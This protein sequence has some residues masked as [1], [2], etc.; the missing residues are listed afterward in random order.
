MPKPIKVSD[1]YF[2]DFSAACKKLHYISEMDQECG[3]VV[4]L[5]GGF[6]VGSHLVSLGGWDRD[7]TYLSVVLNRV[8]SDKT[9]R[10]I[11]AH[12]HPNGVAKFSD[13]DIRFTIG[14]LLVSTVTRL[15]C[16]DHIL[17]PYDRHPVSFRHKYKKIWEKDWMKFFDNQI[18]SSIRKV[19]RVI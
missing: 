1:E 10:Y 2:G 16:V 17:M 4:T 12:N 13:D 11:F 15:E 3:V 7:Q 14:L 19:R 5:D 8:L 9:N 18:I 6:K